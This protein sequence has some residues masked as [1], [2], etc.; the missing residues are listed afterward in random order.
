MRL[1]H[2]TQARYWFRASALFGECFVHRSWIAAFPLKLPRESQPPFIR[3]I[4]ERVYW[5]TVIPVLL[6]L[7]LLLV[8]QPHSPCFVLPFGGYEKIFSYLLP[9]LAVACYVIRRYPRKLLRHVKEANFAA[10][11]HCG[12]NLGGLPEKHVCPECGVEYNLADVK[13]MWQQYID[14]QS[15]RDDGD[16]HVL[17]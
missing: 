8:S 9:F 11:L 1:R 14:C 5:T 7:G 2:L 15:S 12:Y 16:G 10:C 3:R 13:A 17:R 6:I 4:E